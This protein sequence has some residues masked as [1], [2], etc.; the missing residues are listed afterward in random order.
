MS[1][2]RA[3]KTANFKVAFLTVAT[4]FIMGYVNGLAMLSTHL[5]LPVTPQ[6]GNVLWMG[7]NTAFGEWRYL[8][9]NLG[10]FFG[11]MGGAVFALFTQNLFKNKTNQ[12]F[13]NWSVFVVPT[14]LYPILLHYTV[15]AW[16]GFTVIGFASGA[17]LGFFRK[18]YHM[19]QINNAMATGNVRFLG[20]HFA[21]AFLKKDTRGN[22]KEI[23]TFLIFLTCVLAFA[24]GAFL[25]AMMYRLDYALALDFPLSLNYYIYD[26]HRG[27]VLGFAATYNT[28]RIIILAVIC[29]IPYFFFPKTP[30]VA[31]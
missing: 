17:A 6:T 4:I 2:E 8:L 19:D 14:I 23:Q 9:E 3:E 13:Y 20:L 1:A 27:G 25:Y 18:I 29:V 28:I 16:V 24:G 30:K 31:K 12:F 11:F 7:I 10:L 22:K 21:L 5:S 26:P 15:A